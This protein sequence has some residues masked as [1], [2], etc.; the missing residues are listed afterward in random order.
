MPILQVPSTVMSP[1]NAQAT[2]HFKEAFWALYLPVTVAG[3][4]SD[5][6]RSYF[7]QALF[8]SIGL[9]VGFLPRPLV[10]QDRNIHSYAADFE[11]EMPLYIQS[12]ALVRH[13]VDNYVNNKKTV[14]EHNNLMEAME[15]LWVDLYER[16]YVELDDVFNVQLWIQ[17]LLDIGYE[18]PKLIHSRHVDS[19]EG[20]PEDKSDF[21]DFSQYG[22][23]MYNLGQKVLKA[24][25]K[26]TGGPKCAALNVTFVNSDVHE[27]PRTDLSSTL[28][29]LGERMVLMGYK[30]PLNHYSQVMKMPG[31]QYYSQMSPVLEKY[32]D[33]S[34]KVLSTWPFYNHKFYEGDQLIQS[35]DAFICTFPAS[36]CQIWLPFDKAVVILPVHRYNLGRCEPVEWHLLNKQLKLL[37]KEARN[38]IAAASRYDKEYMRYYT[39]LSPRLVPSY[40]GFY[41]S[42]VLY[43]PVKEQLLIFSLPKNNQFP[44]SVK[45]VLQPEFSAEYVYKVYKDYK[46]TDLAGHPAVI[47]MPYSVMSY[48]LTEL[49]ALAIPMFV[50]SPRFYLN[51]YN[52]QQRNVGLG[53]D[54]TMTS[55]PY[56]PNHPKLEAKMRPSLDQGLSYHPYSP[57]VDMAQ[58]PEAEMYWMQ[59]ADFYDWPHI[60]LFDTY[61]HLKELLLTANLPRIHQKMAEELKFKGMHVHEQWCDIAQRIQSSQ[62]KA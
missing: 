2:L 35:A 37:A 54:R 18:F 30:G 15:L 32:R 8:K 58:D 14:G 46:L 55:E 22:T 62:I 49:Y 61:E 39:G 40:S 60:Q 51:Y 26:S 6:W 11:A 10:V 52:K 47:S 25:L 36:Q 24:K 4:V 56:C 9:S 27:G 53:H 42:S 31:V 59:L 1:Y 38:T 45:Q 43:K 33:H 21:P 34:T 41:A 48:R 44:S 23:T 19:N 57:N 50:P 29:T 3:R 12:S 16:G 28:S 20:V 13:L 17:A 5:I 7:A